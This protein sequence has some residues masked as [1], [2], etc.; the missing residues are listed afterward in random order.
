LEALAGAFLGTLLFMKAEFG[1]C[2]R[3]PRA[4]LSPPAR[5][6]V[7]AGARRDSPATARRRFARRAERFFFVASE[8]AIV[9]VRSSQLAALTAQGNRR[10]R[11]MPGR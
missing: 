6:R 1:F 7:G 2:A 8:F 5:Q 3:R 10:A 11:L 4:P 9:K